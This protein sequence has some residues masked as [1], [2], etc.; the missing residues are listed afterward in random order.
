MDSLINPITVLKNKRMLNY[1]R[2]NRP[3]L[4]M[5]HQASW[6]TCWW[7]SP[8]CQAWWRSSSAPRPCT[9]LSRS[10]PGLPPRSACSCVAICRAG[11][12][13]VIKQDRR[14]KLIG[15]FASRPR[16]LRQIQWKKRRKK[17]MPKWCEHL[18][19]VEWVSRWKC[20]WPP[21][22]NFPDTV[23]PLAPTSISSPSS[24]WWISGLN[25]KNNNTYL[26]NKSYHP[27][28]PTWACSPYPPSSRPLRCSALAPPCLCNS[29][30]PFVGR[31]FV[32]LQLAKCTSL[33]AFFSLK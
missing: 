31:V 23:I 16:S 4:Q 18:Q 10:R 26:F 22:A 17:T 19:M 33:L 28:P 5:P 20:S 27:P 1:Y 21:M 15:K 13:L 25:T 11:A 3:S 30:K 7:C 32:K 29:P 6:R 8:W 24:T 14:V 9:A 2:A 12:L